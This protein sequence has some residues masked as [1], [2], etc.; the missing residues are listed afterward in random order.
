MTTL[1]G[2]IASIARQTVTKTSGDEINAITDDNADASEDDDDANGRAMLKRLEQVPLDDADAD[3]DGDAAGGARRTLSVSPG[4]TRKAVGDESPL[5][6]L[7]FV[8]AATIQ[9]EHLGACLCA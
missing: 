1:D 3:E 6:S 4:T 2:L 5:A 9:G 8:V 7:Q